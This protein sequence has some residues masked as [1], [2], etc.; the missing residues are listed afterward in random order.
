MC[1]DSNQGSDSQISKSCSKSSRWGASATSLSTTPKG[2]LE[3]FFLVMVVMQWLHLKFERPRE[4]NQ[5]KQPHLVF[6]VS[7]SPWLGVE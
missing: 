7:G 5:C 2:Q 4:A 3:V 1:T 6:L